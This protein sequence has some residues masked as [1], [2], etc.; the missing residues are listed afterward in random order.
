MSALALSLLAT[1]VPSVVHA[2]GNTDVPMHVD[3]QKWVRK[4]TGVYGPATSFTFNVAPGTAADADERNNAV[5][6]GIE[7]GVVFENDTIDLTPEV[8]S[9][10]NNNVIYSKQ[11]AKLKIVN[12]KFT[13]PGV[14]RYV[15]T[16]TVGDYAGMHY[17]TDS[18]YFDVYVQNGANGM[19]VYS[20]TFVN[21]ENNK[22][23]DSTG[24]G[25][26]NDYGVEPGPVPVTP[27]PTNPNDQPKNE[28][29][30]RNTNTDP[31]KALSK[32]KIKKEVR[33]NQGDKQ[34]D[35]T[36]KLKVDGDAGEKYNVKFNNTSRAAAKI[37]SKG[38]EVTI[39]LKDGEWAEISGL[40]KDD[41]VT[42]TENSYATEGYSTKHKD[43]ENAEAVEGATV[44]NKKITSDD[45]VTFINEKEI[46]TP[47]GLLLEYGPYLLLV[48]AAAGMLVL[49][50]RRRSEEE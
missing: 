9:S 44:E 39:T 46:T 33:G 1:N 21:K 34:K 35:F 38:D 32:L 11:K 26:V 12:D 47:T 5:K 41:K 45:T 10:L 18:K 19:E 16:E 7:G 14:Y 24:G 37:E 8:E 29:P 23:K 3:I 43:G 25:F 2:E 4:E 36:F 15:I 49:S 27:D 50:L 13:S 42:V 48:T 17:R 6:A 31:N 28:E 30:T 20:Y 40:S 22:V